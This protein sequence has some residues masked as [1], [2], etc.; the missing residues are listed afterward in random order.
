MVFETSGFTTVYQPG[1]AWV[2]SRKL[3]EQTGW[4]ENLAYW[5][6]MKR[7]YGM[8]VVGE[9]PLAYWLEI[10]PGCGMDVVGEVS[11]VVV[12]V[13]WPSGDQETVD[14]LASLAPLVTGGVLTT[15]TY[16]GVPK[17]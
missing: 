9:V 13:A 11:G 14:R 12:L 15:S 17:T 6:R 4:K 1:P 7:E 16:D 10:Y 2:A 3:T 5:L 8:D